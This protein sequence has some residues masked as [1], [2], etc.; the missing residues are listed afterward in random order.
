[1]TRLR[2][3]IGYDGSAFHG[4]AAQSGLRTVQGELELWLERFLGRPTPLTCAGRTDAG[5]HARGQV[6]HLDV[7]SDDPDASAAELQRRL[8]LSL[9]HI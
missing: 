5:V 1:M 7:E 2:L 8:A 9:I 6:A 3:D 4:W